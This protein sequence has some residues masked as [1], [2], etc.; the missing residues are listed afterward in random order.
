MTNNEDEYPA[1]DNHVWH[2]W[3]IDLAGDFQEDGTGTAPT[4]GV[5]NDPGKYRCCQSN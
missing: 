4:V 5:R 2:W 1:T 3:T